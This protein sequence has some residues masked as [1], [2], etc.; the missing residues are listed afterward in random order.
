MLEQALPV[1]VELARGSKKEKLPPHVVE[2]RMNKIE[3]LRAMIMD[4]PDGV[5]PGTRRP[6][7]PFVGGSGAGGEITIDSTKVDERQHTADYYKHTEETAA[8]QAEWDEARQRQDVQLDN[9]ETGLGTL[10]EIG[11]AMNEELQA[12]GQDAWGG[13]WGSDCTAAP[14]RCLPAVTAG[15]NPHDGP[16]HPP[17]PRP[18]TRSGMT[19]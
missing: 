5:H 12:C 19:C 16:P 15:H 7:G 9:I 2:D 8:F 13:Y 11:L 14:V 17:S 6:G 3:E 1:L 18:F 4:V 10:K